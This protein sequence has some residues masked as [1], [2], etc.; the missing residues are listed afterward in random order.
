[1]NSTNQSK[2]IGPIALLA[3]GVFLLAAG[4]LVSLVNRSNQTS[5]DSNSDPAITVERVLL[6]EAFRAYQE[7]SAVLVDVRSASSFE[8]GHIPGSLSI[9]ISEVERRASELN[10]DNWIITICA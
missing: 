6:D 10:P 4:L 7:G 1:M 8:S 9:P 5:T 3:A 2:W